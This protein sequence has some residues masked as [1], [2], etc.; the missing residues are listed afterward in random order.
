MSITKAKTR[1]EQIEYIKRFVLG[2]ADFDILYRGTLHRFE[3]GEFSDRPEYEAE[4]ESQI[5]NEISSFFD[6]IL[7][8][9]VPTEDTRPPYEE[10]TRQELIDEDIEEWNIMMN[11]FHSQIL[12]RYKTGTYHYET[13]N[14]GVLLQV[15]GEQHFI[16]YYGLS[17][18][19]EDQ[20]FQLPYP[21]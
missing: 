17:L 2:N 3:S 6:E 8:P 10:V 7:M 9:A 15:P 16:P 19:F 14:E 1:E 13:S 20:I 12:H 4:I 21:G 18:W 11:W 5:N